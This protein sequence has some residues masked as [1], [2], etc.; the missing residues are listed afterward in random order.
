[1]DYRFNRYNR[2]LH[3]NRNAQLEAQNLALSA[4]MTGPWRFQNVGVAGGMAKIR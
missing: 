2:A 1:M 3:Y 4:I